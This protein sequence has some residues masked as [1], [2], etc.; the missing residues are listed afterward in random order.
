MNSKRTKK[1]KLYEI[2]KAMQDIK[3]GFTE[4]KTV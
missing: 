2:M 1:S 4:E 3:G